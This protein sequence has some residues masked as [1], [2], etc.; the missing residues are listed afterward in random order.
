[1]DSLRA[2]DN[3]AKQVQKTPHRIALDFIE[4]QIA[5][6]ELIGPPRTA[7]H[8]TVLAMT[9]KNGFVVIGKSAPADPANYDADLGQKFA[10]E[11]CIRQAWPLFAFALR[12]KLAEGD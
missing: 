7:S 9:F 6:V 2:T 11:D 1:M 8:M 5:E 10:R 4:S 3:A 12:D